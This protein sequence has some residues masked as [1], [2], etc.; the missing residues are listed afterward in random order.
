MGAKCSCGAEIRWV[1]MIKKVKVDGG[2]EWKKTGSK[3]PVDFP[4]SQRVVIDTENMLGV[5]KATAVSHFA[6][7]PNSKK[8]RKVPRQKSLPMGNIPGKVID[9]PHCG[10]AGDWMSCDVCENGQVVIG[11]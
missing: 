5:V 11:A 7:C 1:E 8:H 9:C 10:G 4:F 2:F 6:T 3:M